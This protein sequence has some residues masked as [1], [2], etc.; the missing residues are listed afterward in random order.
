[1]GAV[2]SQRNLNWQPLPLAEDDPTLGQIIGREL[3]AYSITGYD[4]NEV[5]SHFPRHVGEHFRAVVHLNPKSGVGER[6]RDDALN[7]KCF[8]LVS[9]GQFAPLFYCAFVYTSAN[10]LEQVMRPTGC[11]P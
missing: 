10:C 8:F 6:L 1:M 9:H 2:R 3:N 5:F 4:S 7:L 11:L